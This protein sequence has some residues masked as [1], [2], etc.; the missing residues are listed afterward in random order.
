[1]ET[2]TSNVTHWQVLQRQS[3]AA[4]LIL[5]WSIALKLLKALWP[6]L[7]LYFF[8]DEKDNDSLWLF[9]ILMGFSSFSLMGAIIGYWFKKFK[10][11]DETL[12]I[13]SGWLR[14][15]VLSIPIQSIQAVHLEQN[16]WQQALKVAKVN[17][18]ST[19][20][21]KVEV[22]L[23]ALSIEKAEEL[24][25]L[26]IDRGIVEPKFSPETPL[27]NE[28]KYTL[29]F[30]DL[31]KLS[32]TANHLEAFFIL[33]ALGLNIFD[34][35]RQIFDGSDYLESYVEHLLGQTVIFLLVL[36]I[37]I[38]L[39]SIVYSFFRTL[40]RFYGFELIDSGKRWA[41][42]YGLF[43]R[44]KKI[45]P[46]NKIQIISWSANWLRRKF[47]YWTIQVQSVGQKENGNSNV[48]IPV[49]SLSQV[50]QLAGSYK[51]FTE[52]EYATSYKIEPDYWKRKS[53]LKGLPLTLIAMIVF[54]YWIEW[55]VFGFI[56]LFGFLVWYYYQWYQHFRWQ[57]NETG[58]QILSGF[59]GR[60]FTLLSWKKIQ[61]VHIHQSLYQKTHQL[62]N[63][64]FITAGGKVTLPYLSLS[65]A[66]ALVN[67]VLHDVESKEESWM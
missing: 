54:F 38:A 25:N 42:S 27:E 20:S 59:F 12:I 50:F 9:W 2:S 1:M 62:A 65:T 45:I 57:T 39:I 24:R 13:E 47:H 6:I 41:I 66:N 33:L 23:D 10:I 63:V 5:L 18:D 32:L 19:G 14:K 49:T 3:P 48:L 40:I 28:K 7:I 60:K 8:K 16:V 53:L 46:T 35:V 51:E 56:L 52:I 4:I 15:K 21:G 31:V 34:E 22:K 36:L 17:F 29:V 64:I 44:T 30:S 61:Q 67:Y 11:N 37:G 43:D 58:I 55:Q 26:L